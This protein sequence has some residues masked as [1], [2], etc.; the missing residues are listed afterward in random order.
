MFKKFQI[1]LVNL[2]PVRGA[3]ISKTR[4]CLIVSPDEMNNALSKVIVVPLTSPPPRTLPTRIM[5][6]STSSS[7]LAND[8]YAVLDQ[9]KTID[10]TRI[11]KTIGEISEAE[12]SE[13]TGR[14]LELFDY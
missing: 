13:I 2:D 9:I 5:I 10:K 3:E 6:K 14:L 8:S 12:K 7:A 4:P 1:V 11:H